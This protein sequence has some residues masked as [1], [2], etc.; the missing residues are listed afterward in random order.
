MGHGWI[1]SLGNPLIETNT[2]HWT[3][4]LER[5]GA[6]DDGLQMGYARF[7]ECRKNFATHSIWRRQ[8]CRSQRADH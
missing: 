3:V 8:S 6:N 7:T 1:E 2:Q 4:G 5:G